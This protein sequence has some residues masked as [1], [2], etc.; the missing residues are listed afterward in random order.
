MC[1]DPVHDGSKS[2]GFPFREAFCAARK[3]HGDNQ[4]AVR[5]NQSA[6]RDTIHKQLRQPGGGKEQ[7]R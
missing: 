3:E 4:S 7:G 1:A 5:D 2:D 6:V